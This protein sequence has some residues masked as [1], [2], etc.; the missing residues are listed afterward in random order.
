MERST[1]RCFISE[2]RQN[3]LLCYRNRLDQS[4]QEYFNS[5]VNNALSY[6]LIHEMASRPDIRM[7]FYGL[8]SLDGPASIDEFKLRMGY[9]AKPVRQRV[10]FHPLLETFV[11]RTGTAFEKMLFGRYPRSPLLRKVE[12]MLR[13]YIDGKRAP[14]E[15]EW[16][17][18]LEPRKSEVLELLNRA[19]H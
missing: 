7:V 5:Y 12:G 14:N 1:P 10:V 8:H 3:G 9:K 4:H 2:S 11:N 19:V 6:E 15:Q 16:P 17:E 13:F 18:C